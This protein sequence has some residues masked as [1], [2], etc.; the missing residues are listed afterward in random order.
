MA[1]LFEAMLAGAIVVAVVTDLTTFDL[2][3]M[4]ALLGGFNASFLSAAFLLATAEI[5]A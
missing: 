2:G 3:G 1:T 4:A 5:L